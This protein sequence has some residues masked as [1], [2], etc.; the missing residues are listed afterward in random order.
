[1]KDC[2]SIKELIFLYKQGKKICVWGC[3]Y[4]AHTTCKDILQK[5]GIVPY[6]FCDINEE[7]WGKEVYDGILCVD[8]S[9]LDIRDDEAIWIICVRLPLQKDVIN[10]LRELGYTSYITITSVS[11][12]YL[13]VNKY[14]PF[15]EQ[16]IV[17]Y[18][19]IVG[20]YDEIHYPSE[21]LSAKY[22]YV[23]ISDNKPNDI[24]TFK[25][26]IDVREVCPKE[27]VDPTRMNR[28]CKINS[29]KLF[30]EYNMSIYMDGCIQ[31]KNNVDT[32]CEK[33][34]WSDIGLTV[35]SKTGYKDTY[36]EAAHKMG[37]DVD[38]PKLIYN[39][40]KAYWESG[41]PKGYGSWYC[42]LLIRR[43]NSLKCRKI[44]SDWWGEVSRYSRRD[45]LSFPYVLWKNGI[46][47]N[48]IETILQDDQ[49]FENND[50]YEYYSHNNTMKKTF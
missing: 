39:Q 18:T 45:Q 38:D 32:I 20:G 50:Y 3:G 12:D 43:H 7:L 42:T 29:H 40:I 17:A 11:G 13:V 34:L 47:A 9:K 8:Y 46:C 25:K 16:K 33:N 6:C 19:C 28:Y 21:E 23:L 48:D 30:P 27:I 35:V 15:M 2:L 14:F 4:L 24:K 22:D 49:S 5:L 10:K 44:M 37:Q 31:L 41:L 36:S 26:W 1:M